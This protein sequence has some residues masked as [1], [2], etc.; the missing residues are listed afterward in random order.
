MGRA[1][2][3]AALLPAG[4]TRRHTDVAAAA[5]VVAAADAAAAVAAEAVAAPAIAAASVAAGAKYVGQWKDDTK[6]G[7]GT[8]TYAS[9]KVH[10]K[11]EW[12]NGK[13]KK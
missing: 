9:G 2:A 8:Y 12:E 1:R 11:G 6:H 5:A 4:R 3:A 10:H 7:F 13:P